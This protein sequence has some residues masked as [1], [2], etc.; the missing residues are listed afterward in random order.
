MSA[1]LAVDDYPRRRY[2][3]AFA[4]ADPLVA[5][6]LSARERCIDPFALFYDCLLPDLTREPETRPADGDFAPGFDV[7]RYLRVASPTAPT[8]PPAELERRHP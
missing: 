8:A 5:V 7:L 4:E 6:G 1:P 3:F 2:L